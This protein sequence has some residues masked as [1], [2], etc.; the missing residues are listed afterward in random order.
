MENFFVTFGQK[1]HQKPHPITARELVFDEIGDKF[2]FMY[3]ENDFK[4]GY[5]PAGCFKTL[6]QED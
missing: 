5:F 6:T 3:S 4:E 1:Y 2:A